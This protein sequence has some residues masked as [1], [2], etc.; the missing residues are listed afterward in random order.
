MINYD[1]LLSTILIIQF[2]KFII[3]RHFDNTYVQNN[4][5]TFI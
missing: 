4:T 5:Y 2:K 3:F 1:H